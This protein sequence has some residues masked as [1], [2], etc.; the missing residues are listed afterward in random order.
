MEISLYFSADE[1]LR[2]SPTGSEWVF[3]A[4]DD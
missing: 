4:S 1:I 3:P 2:Y